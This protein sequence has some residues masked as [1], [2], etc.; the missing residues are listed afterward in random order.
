MASP[1]VI[2]LDSRPDRWAALSRDWRGVFPLSRVSAVSASPGW[3]GCALS[4][5]KAVEDAKQRGDPYVLVWEDDCTPFNHTPSQVRDLWNEVLYKLSL[6]KGEWDVVTGGTTNADQG[7]TFNP[8]LSTR[9]VNVY[10]LP[11]G[12]TTHWVL[13]NSSSYDRMIAWKNVQ[14]PQIDVYIYQQFRV[15]IILPF[16]AVQANGYSNIQGGT[17]SYNDLFMNAE[18]TFRRSSTFGS[19]TSLAAIVQ[20][21]L[22]RVA[23]PKFMAR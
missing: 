12:F 14:A 11:F 2:N 23:T 22:A 8:T 5:V 9:N 10:D 6:Y 18:R 19:K 4:H 21:P 16:L 3:L 15:K 7:S 1:Y 20:S 13:Y 17:T